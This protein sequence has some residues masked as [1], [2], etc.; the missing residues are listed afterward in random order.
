M[1]QTSRVE[2]PRRTFSVS[3][4]DPT[5]SIVNS[6]LHIILWAN[7]LLTQWSCVTTRRRRDDAVGSQRRT[8][9]SIWRSA[10]LRQK[11]SPKQYR[12]RNSSATNLVYFIYPEQER[13]SFLVASTAHITVSQ[14]RA[15]DCFFAGKLSSK[16]CR[17][18]SLLFTTPWTT[19]WQADLNLYI[20]VLTV[21]SSPAKIQRREFV[22]QFI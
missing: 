9:Y 8:Q 17:Q 18:N 16:N 7:G 1:T 20:G 11:T 10:R 14:S 3:R 2:L 12:R 22:R 13:M 21:F 15:N 19:R 4:C 5:P 6:V